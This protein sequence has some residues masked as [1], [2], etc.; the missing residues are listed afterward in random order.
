ML[1]AMG[2]S[3]ARGFAM[4]RAAEAMLRAVG[5]T[6][7]HVIRVSQKTGTLQQRQLGQ[8]LPQYNDV[9]VGPAV[10]SAE[11]VPPAAMK[12]KIVMPARVVRKFAEQEGEPSGTQWL[13]GA[14]GIMHEGTLLRITNVQAEF[15]AG[16][17]YVYRVTAEV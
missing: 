5:A 16:V 2:A 15:L 4:A 11:C 10:V 1:D 13:A 17:E 12:L 3:A 8:A 9:V 7:V 14:R 6:N